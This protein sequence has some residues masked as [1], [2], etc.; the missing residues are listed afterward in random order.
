MR[1]RRILLK[2]RK[3]RQLAMAQLL[4]VVAYPSFLT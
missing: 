3:M 2:M 4:A 1:K